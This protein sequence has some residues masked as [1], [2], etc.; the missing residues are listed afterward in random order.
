M[1]PTVSVVVPVYNALP[2]LTELLDSLAA[3]DI[4]AGSL[5][6]VTVDDGS[7]DGSADA[8]D[9]YCRRHEHFSVI[10]QTNSRRPGRPRNV[11]LRASESTYVFFADADDRL[12]PECLRR[13]V[14]CAE[15]QGSD[16]VIPKMVP[17]AGRGFPTAVYEKTLLDADLVTAFRTLFP[18]KLYRRSLLTAHDIWFPEGIRLDDGNFNAQVY[19]H[20]KRISILSDYDYYFLRAR[21]VGR[22]LSR[23][24]RDPVS[25]TAS[26]VKL[27]EIVREHVKD[28]VMVDQ[29]VLDLYR[30]KCLHEYDPR[31]FSLYDAAI[32]DAWIAVH[33]SLAERFIS[34]DLER[35]LE[36]PFRE[37][38][39]FIRRG[40]RAGLLESSR[41]E[42]APV[43]TATVTR[44][45]WAG[46][47]LEVAVTTSV[48]G[49]LGLP[50][51]LI[52]QLLRRD[53][54]GGSA[55]PITR[56]A[57]ETR[58]AGQPARYE[59]VLPHRS[60]QALFAGTY[61]V[62]VVSVSG[63]ERLSG[64]ACWGEGVAVPRER[65]GL[66]IHAT[67][68]GQVSVKKTVEADLDLR[69]VLGRVAGTLGWRH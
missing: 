30:R 44:A 59:G 49:R 6:V 15:E 10:H 23:T 4:E 58:D 56:Q 34:E 26:V 60:I 20:A 21:K 1:K 50:R 11:G 35:R 48:R 55:F 28:P 8:L 14:T 57:E 37:R 53:G 2:Y 47:D 41:H 51:Q 69:A 5:N 24:E 42:T 64:R 33:K 36:S 46:G 31:R 19:V 27:L 61:D 25:Y 54:D 39:Y 52:C 9:D 29:V 62:H 38:S 43:V 67:R 22:H 68:N 32:Q 18:Q 40:D 3:Q 12:A 65:A 66:R 16:V 17:L 63:Q 7:T 13:L 45:G